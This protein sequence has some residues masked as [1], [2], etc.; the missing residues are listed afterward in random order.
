[1]QFPDALGIGQAVALGAVA[2]GPFLSWDTKAEPRG[3]PDTGRDIG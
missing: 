1:V 2:S 3:T